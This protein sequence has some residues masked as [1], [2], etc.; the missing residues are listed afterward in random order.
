M[1]DIRFEEEMLKIIGNYVFLVWEVFI[2]I[3]L[4]LNMVNNSW[5]VNIY[6]IFKVLMFLFIYFYLFDYVMGEMFGY[7]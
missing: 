5:F 1:G 3:K 2:Y 7:E 4:C 6:I